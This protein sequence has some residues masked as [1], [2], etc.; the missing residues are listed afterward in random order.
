MKKLCP[1]T[2]MKKV[3]MFP[4]TTKL[5]MAHAVSSPY[6]NV[7]NVF[8]TMGSIDDPRYRNF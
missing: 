8:M 7:K 4:Q 2:S 1:F 6:N 3:R 5:F